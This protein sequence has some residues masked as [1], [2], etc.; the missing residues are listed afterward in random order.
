MQDARRT[1]RTACSFAHVWRSVLRERNQRRTHARMVLRQRVGVG[2]HAAAVVE[3]AC[4]RCVRACRCWG[5]GCA[6]CVRAAQDKFESAHG[7]ELVDKALEAG[8]VRAFSL[9][10]AFL[11]QE[12][13][14][15]PAHVRVSTHAHMRTLA[16]TD[17]RWA[18]F[19]PALCSLVFAGNTATANTCGPAQNRR[20]HA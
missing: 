6:A 5:V 11:P 2:M 20:M 14:H 4:G 9:I 3:A 18:S 16:R 1:H 19:G 10:L 12:C 8:H 15:E 13:R 7:L 17:T